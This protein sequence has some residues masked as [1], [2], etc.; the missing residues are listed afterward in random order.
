MKTLRAF[1]L[2]GASLALTSAVIVAG[3]LPGR[4][5]A[6]SSAP[7]G[8]VS[9]A[10]SASASDTNAADPFDYILDAGTTNGQYDCSTNVGTN[11]TVT[12]SNL[13]PSFTYY[14]AVVAEDTNT[15][16]VSP[17]SGQISWRPAS[18]P[19]APPFKGITV[20]AQ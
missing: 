3:I 12:V 5:V 18:P 17:Y 1:L 9:L 10:W 19:P 2:A 15:G 11:L 4:P 6:P 20:L 13:A 8:A 7:L 14:F 16:L